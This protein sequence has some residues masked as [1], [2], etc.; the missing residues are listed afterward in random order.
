[1]TAIRGIG[2]WRA[3]ALALAALAGACGGGGSH[4]WAAVEDRAIDGSG[5]NLTHHHWGRAGSP[6][7]RMAAAAYE[8]GVAA[9]ARAGGPNPRAVSNAIFAQTGDLPNA[10][11]MSAMVF[12]WGQFVDHDLD[13]TGAAAPAEPMDIPIPTG[14]PIFD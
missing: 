13:L 4:D 12:Q 11:G 9:P 3:F 14:D 5:N 6:L 10:G 8:D 7:G 2:A 1:M